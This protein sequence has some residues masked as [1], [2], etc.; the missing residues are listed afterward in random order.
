MLIE[1]L[2]PLYHYFFLI[3]RNKLVHKEKKEKKKSIKTSMVLT[4]NSLVST[5]E[6][7]DPVEFVQKNN[8]YLAEPTNSD[9]CIITFK[10]MDCKINGQQ[11]EEKPKKESKKQLSDKLDRY[12]HFSFRGIR[13]AVDTEERTVECN[14]MGLPSETISDRDQDG[15]Y[16]LNVET[17]N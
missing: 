14:G 2:A 5:N 3:R 1:G 16:K 17:S 13:F 11:V 8:E 6:D 4:F 12:M 15:L 7:V 10:L 9:G